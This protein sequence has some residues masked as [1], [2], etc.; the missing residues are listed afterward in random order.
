MKIER[1]G[2][3]RVI[4]ENPRS[5]HNYF[6]WPTIARLKD[7]RLAAAAS[8]YRLTHVCPFGKAVISFSE[9]EGETWTLPT[10]VIDTVLDDRDAGLCPFGENGLILTS[11]NDP[12][13][14]QLRYLETRKYETWNIPYCREYLNMISPEEEDRVLGSE[15]RVSFDGGRTFGPIHRS[16][17]T[18]PHGPI[19]LTDGSILW[20]GR[21]HHASRWDDGEEG[22]RAY[23]MFPDG[24]AE[25]LGH[26]PD[27]RD[28]AGNKLGEFHEPY[29]Y[30]LQDGTIICH[31]R[32]EPMFTTYQSE[33][34]DG[35]R[36]WTPVHALLGE[37]GGAPAHI[38]EHSSGVLL[39]AYGFRQAPTGGIRVM[40][41]TD[42]GKTWD[43]DN[44]LYKNSF[45]H[46]DLGYPVTVE[47]GDGSLLT[48]FYAHVDDG[49]VYDDPGD[50][51]A[52]ILQQ[53]WRI[54]E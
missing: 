24:R 41:S 40:F 7:G 17:V 14:G 6:A 43:K 53:R 15:F 38:M 21:T 37:Q 16:P 47:L 19:E 54:A 26:I 45:N 52:V 1:I 12:T 42:G 13:A 27:L 22:V 3:P 5:I 25:Y 4:M 30:E 11:F 20:V 49:K 35:G 34:H 44:I 29:A 51:P 33:S 8:G 2:E 36:T 46:T 10:P 39:S 23:R 32:I 48:V 50:G 18:S 31:L 28:D 9:D